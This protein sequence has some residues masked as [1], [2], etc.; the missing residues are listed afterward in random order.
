MKMIIMQGGGWYIEGKN[1]FHSSFT[2]LHAVV[3]NGWEKGKVHIMN[4][5]EGQHTVSEDVFFDSYEAVGSHAV[6]VKK[7]S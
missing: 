3:L 1:E 6:I 5:L 7:L 2:N 4:P